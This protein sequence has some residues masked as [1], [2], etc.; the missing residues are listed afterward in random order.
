[1]H[2]AAPPAA[3]HGTSRA[4][5]AHTAAA[6]VR[7]L[8]GCCYQVS[9][10][11]AKLLWVASYPQEVHAPRHGGCLQRGMAG[12]AAAPGQGEGGEWGD[13]VS[14]QSAV[15]VPACAS[16][17]PAK[18]AVRSCDRAAGTPGS[19]QSRV[20]PGLGWYLVMNTAKKAGK[21]SLRGASTVLCIAAVLTAA[22]D[23]GS[24]LRLATMSRSMCSSGVACRA[25]MQM[26]SI[27]RKALSNTADNCMQ[28]NA[29]PG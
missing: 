3:L 22:I 27:S 4:H 8:R 21:T 11:D 24:A 7:G 23:D 28:C 5:K 6:D 26:Q 17:Q 25:A 19:G 16:V 29:W 15:V 14:S 1:M 2:S 13:R 10:E 20:A 18:G 12:H 9:I